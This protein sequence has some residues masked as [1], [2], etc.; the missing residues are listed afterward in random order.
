MENQSKLEVHEDDLISEWEFRRLQYTQSTEIGDFYTLKSV[1]ELS[2]RL[3]IDRQVWPLDTL[4]TELNVFRLA[5]KDLLDDPSQY[6]Y[7][8]NTTWVDLIFV[9]RVRMLF[10]YLLPNFLAHRNYELFEWFAKKLAD[11]FEW[12]LDFDECIDLD[13]SIREVC[14]M[15]EA[16]EWQFRRLMLLG[17]ADPIL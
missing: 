6:S 3:Q 16:R 12:D 11:D 7:Y 13:W 1:E 10:E 17:N 4:K 14:R 5:T 15:S 9:D 8:G 2:D